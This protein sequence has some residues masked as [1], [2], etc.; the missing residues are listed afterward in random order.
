MPVIAITSQLILERLF[1]LPALTL[2][3]FYLMHSDR[4][5]LDAF[6]CENFALSLV[7]ILSL[8]GHFI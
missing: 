1:Q 4:R 5:H 6:N 7:I 8:C 3:A 2:K